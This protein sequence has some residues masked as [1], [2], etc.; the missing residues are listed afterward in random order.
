M[1]CFFPWH[2]EDSL[3]LLS[4]VADGEADGGRWNPPKYIFRVNIM[5]GDTLI[6]ISAWITIP[7]FKLCIYNFGR[8]PS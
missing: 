5:S 1:P 3:S 8:L 6:N 2:E 4:E 7:F